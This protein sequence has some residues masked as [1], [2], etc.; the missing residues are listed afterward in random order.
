MTGGNVSSKKY[1]NF[2]GDLGFEVLTALRPKMANV[3]EVHHQGEAARNLIRW[4]TSTRVYVATTQKTFPGV[5]FGGRTRINGDCMN[6]VR[7]FRFGG[8]NVLAARHMGTVV[9]L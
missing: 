4:Y 1:A 5:L 3:S 2:L 9:L 8:C 6:S 7:K